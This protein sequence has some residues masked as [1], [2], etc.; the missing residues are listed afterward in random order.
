MLQTKP[1]TI[2]EQLNNAKEHMND[3]GISQLMV[4]L[5]EKVDYIDPIQFFS[6][7]QNQDLIRLFWKDSEDS[8]YLV[9]IDQFKT[10]ET[11]QNRFD[12]I[13]K[14]REEL[15]NQIYSPNGAEKGTGPV[16][17]GGFSF[18]DTIYGEKWDS[19][20]SGQ[21]IIPKTL[22]TVNEDDYYMTYNVTLTENTDVDEL[23]K[24][25][26]SY[27]SRSH[28]GKQNSNQQLQSTNS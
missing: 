21:M 5:V 18:N 4:S 28:D 25:L 7:F 3:L 12:A 6:H 19:F 15:L 1:L 2:L 8:F 27:K 14:K 16:M 26:Y 23:Y 24:E 11:S 13:Q 9:G 10:I 17:L 20:N 22:L